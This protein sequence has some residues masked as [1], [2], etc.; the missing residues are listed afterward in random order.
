MKRVIIRLIVFY[1]RTL[2]PDTGSLRS[3]Y[4]VSGV[5]RMFPSCS[6]YMK[7][8]IE[9]YGTSKG[10]IRGIFRIGRCHPFQKNLIDMP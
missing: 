5:C 9:K 10:V 2:S 3:L 4:P 1:Q 7:V 8:A 6:E